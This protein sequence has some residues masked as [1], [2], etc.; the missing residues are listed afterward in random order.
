VVELVDTL[1]SKSN[2]SGRA[3]SIPA[4]S[5]KALVNHLIF[6]GYFDLHTQSCQPF[7]KSVLF[8]RIYFINSESSNSLLS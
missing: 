1:D 8:E 5:T 2:A 4:L 7:F 3:G 6:K